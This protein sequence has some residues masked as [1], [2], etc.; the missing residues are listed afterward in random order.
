MLNRGKISNMQQKLTHQTSEENIS[1]EELKN[2]YTTIHFDEALELCQKYITKIATHAFRRESDPA[3]KREMTQKYIYEFVDSQKPSVE[4]FSDFAVLKHALTDEITQYGP[5][6]K[7]MED[8]LIDEIRANGPEQIFVESGGKTLP[9]EQTFNDREHMERIISK[10][11]G[12][13]KVRLT[14]KIPMVNAR[15]IEGYRV[16]ATHA[17]ISPYDVPAFVIRKF[18]KKSI[19][20]EIMIRNESFSVNM[21]KFL[22]LIPKADLSW[23]TVGPTGSGKTTLNEILVKEINPLSRMI[24]IE[25]PSEMRL[26]QREGDSEHGRVINDVLQYESV[27]EDDD[28]SP[29]TM[30]NLLINAMRQ[31]PHWIGPGELRTPGEFATALRAAQTG[32]YFFTTLHAE[33]DKEAIYRFLTAYLMVSNEPAE[34]ALRNICSAVKFIIFQEKLADGTRKVTAISEVLGS[35]GLEPII[36]PI[37]K[38][39]CEDVLEEESTHRV[40]KIIGRH[41]RVGM[42]SEK[43]Q[44]CML[45][46]GIKK[47]R[48]DFLTLETSEQEEEV[49]N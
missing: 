42:L 47:S 27:S 22:S 32:H 20:P 8:P 13:S 43:V 7:A 17:E 5:I 16:N 46:A 21:F 45:K 9:W 23:I 3:R 18:S 24:T 34:L 15:T 1:G 25:N 4:G 10:L 35:D 14:P 28:S 48:F 30:E 26:L 49:Y 40:L 39:I 19:T 37:Y 36:N 31:S 12:V 38:F 2:R 33:G 44:Q 6:T 29:A 11:I 41:K